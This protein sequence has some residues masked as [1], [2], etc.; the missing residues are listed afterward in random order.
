MG[1]GQT[2]GSEMDPGFEVISRVRS[3]EGKYN[4]LRDRALIINQNMIDQ[5]QRTNSEMKSLEEDIKEVKHSVFQ[6]KETLKHLVREIENFAR[7]DE[8]NVLE[9][10]INLWNP[11]NF[12]TEAEV[13]RLIE[14]SKKKKKS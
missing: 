6:I 7:K 9:R 12:V 14:E 1:N 3:L 8:M 10:Y 2:S 11:L 13:K 4:L 5:Y